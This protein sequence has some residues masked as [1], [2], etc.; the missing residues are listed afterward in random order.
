MF[1]SIGIQELILIF[2]IALLL[3]GP[4]KIPEIGKAI[5][6]AIK[7]FK[8]ASNE[9]KETIEKEVEEEEEKEEPYK[10]GEGKAG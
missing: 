4:K 1:G 3:F 6:K 9:I 2:I 8:R 5:G 10:D 7:E